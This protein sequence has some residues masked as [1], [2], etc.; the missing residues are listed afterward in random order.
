MITTLSAMRLSRWNRSRIIRSLLTALMP[1]VAAFVGGCSSI[2]LAY[3]NGATLSWWWL[4]G[5]L[6][7]SREQTPAVKQGLDKLFEWHRAT[8]LSSYL[9]LL[10]AA[11]AQIADPTTPEKA[12]RWQAQGRELVEPTLDRALEQA[13]ELLPGLGEPQLRSLE[14][15]YVKV[16]AEM[17][18]N[19]L[20]PDPAERHAE[21]I[22][23]AQERAEM[24]YGR[25]GA[26]Q[27]QIIDA[28]VRASP[29]NPELWLQERQRRQRD[30]VQTL[31]RLLQDKADRDQRL[32]ALRTLV[33]RVERSPDPEYRAYQLKLADYN[34][35]F[36]AQIHNSTSAAQRKAARE[37][38]KGWEADFRQIVGKD[39]ASP[40]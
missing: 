36:A 26:A 2:T 17:R 18:D 19:Y 15:R 11:Q 6:D 37:T 38:L 13:A 32:A 30:T 40:S 5:Y 9:P 8:Q 12:C 10:T 4:D 39:P 31:R 29:F 20:Q 24:L 21:S 34:C 35:A 14:K 7:F 22:K 16:L 27:K 28:G 33:A 3:S 23:R 25:L 1:L